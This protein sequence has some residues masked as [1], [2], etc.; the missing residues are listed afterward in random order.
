MGLGVR[1]NMANP[2]D[3]V[4]QALERSGWRTEA[5]RELAGMGSS[6]AAAMEELVAAD[7]AVDGQCSRDAAAG[8]DAEAE[9]AERDG[10]DAA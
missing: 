9:P 5:G 7:G 10:D 8:D 4:P 3:V 2:E 6:A 1:R